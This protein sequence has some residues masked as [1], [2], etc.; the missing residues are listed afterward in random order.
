MCVCEK[1]KT[2]KKFNLILYRI[3]VLVVTNVTLRNI[4]V[5]FDTKSGSAW[6]TRPAWLTLT[7]DV[8]GWRVHVIHTHAFRAYVIRSRMKVSGSGS[9]G[10]VTVARRERGGWGRSGWWGKRWICLWKLSAVEE[11]E[12]RRKG[13]VCYRA[14]SKHVT[15][16]FWIILNCASI[17]FL[18]CN[19]YIAMEADVL[20]SGVEV[21][22]QFLFLL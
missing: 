10:F 13:R 11:P 5:W 16:C 14:K 6:M 9:F 3:V 18:L 8:G 19:I 20:F 22:W 4:N 21:F 2:S 7:G 15:F 12:F 17:I 1:I